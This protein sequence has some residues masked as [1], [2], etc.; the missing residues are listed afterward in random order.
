MMP[1]MNDSDPI[2]NTVESFIEDISKSYPKFHKVITTEWHCGK[3]N[4]N[5]KLA[6]KYCIVLETN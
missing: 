1:M 4:A 5:K 6:E 2:N 3:C